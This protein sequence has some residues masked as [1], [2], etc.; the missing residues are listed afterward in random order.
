MRG[1]R[2]K[3]I[4]LAFIIVMIAPIG[5]AAT[6]E[7][8]AWRGSIYIVA[9]FAGIIA[10][11]LL[12][13]Q[14]L[15]IGGYLP[16]I[17]PRNNRKFHKGIG[18]LLV[19]MVIIHVLFLWVTSPPDVIDVLLFRSPTPFSLWGVIAMWAVFFMGMMAAF[20]KKLRLPLRVWQRVHL[21]LA[22]IT[23]VGSVGHALLIEGTMEQVTKITICILVIA[24]T[25][26]IVIKY[27]N[28][29]TNQGSNQETQRNG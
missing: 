27:L 17:S 19:A 23:V 11:A 21:G 3:L 10:M 18:G 28:Q 1:I 9:G 24:A 26:K 13:A 6:S 29:G 15:L 2:A 7:L 22:I 25:L 14:P 4:W 5:A 12:L 16:S 20:R 8:L